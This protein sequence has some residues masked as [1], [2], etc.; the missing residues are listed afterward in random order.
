MTKC[1]AG[2]G[3]RKIRIRCVGKGGGGGDESGFRWLYG[4]AQVQRG[5]CR[6]TGRLEDRDRAR[7]WES[8]RCCGG[9]DA[10]ELENL[11]NCDCRKMS[12]S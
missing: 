6:R 4:L 7:R 2:C 10:E 12:T 8:I 3:C 11:E 1:C 9:G 5:R